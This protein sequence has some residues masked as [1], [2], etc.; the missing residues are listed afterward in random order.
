MEIWNE[1]QPYLVEILG[2]IGIV[3]TIITTKGKKS[4]AEKVKGKLDKA[5]ATTIKKEKELKKAYEKE[6]KLQKEY[7]DVTSK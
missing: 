1:I 2:S 6:V 4:A 3:I 5:A 7:K